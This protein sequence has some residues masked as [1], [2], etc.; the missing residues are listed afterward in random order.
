ME[1]P[2]DK[3]IEYITGIRVKSAVEIIIDVAGRI[4]K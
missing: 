3:K 2:I 1:K 4:I